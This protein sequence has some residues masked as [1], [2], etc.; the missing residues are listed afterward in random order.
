[1]DSNYV[2]AI[3]AFI[4][5]VIILASIFLALTGRLEMID[6]SVQEDEAA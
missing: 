4:S 1:V 5:L 3:F 2:W 6:D